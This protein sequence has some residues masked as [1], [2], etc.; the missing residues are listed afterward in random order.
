MNPGD[1]ICDVG[2]ELLVRAAASG[3]E[4]AWYELVRRYSHVMTA[5]ARGYRLSEA[6]ASDAVAASWMSLVRYIGTIR[7]G[8]QIAS[9]LVTTVRRESLNQLKQ[10]R[11]EQPV[12]EF[13]G[14]EPVLEQDLDE[15]L[16]AAERRTQVR[17]ALAELPRRQRELLILLSAEPDISYTEV[18]A[19]LGIPIGSIGPTRRRALTRVQEV[20]ERQ[21]QE[22]G[23]R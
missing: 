3:D 18:S 9:W 20:L 16:V 5:A 10:H 15:G 19:A 21:A 13:A 8:R 14:I 4:L 7:D 6:Q 2:P 23:V 1:R 12:A 22:Q 11:R 17:R